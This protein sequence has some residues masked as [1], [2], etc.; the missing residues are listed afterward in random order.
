MYSYRGD[1]IHLLVILLL[2]IL[3]SPFLVW[4]NLNV[5]GYV[6]ATELAFGLLTFVG[7]LGFLIHKKADV[8]YIIFKIKSVALTANR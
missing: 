3:L 4:V 5:W 7:N 1:L 8:L 6:H 2:S